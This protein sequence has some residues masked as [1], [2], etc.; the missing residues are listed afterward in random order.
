MNDIGSKCHM[1]RYGYFEPYA[2]SKNTLFQ[3]RE[4]FFDHGSTN[5]FAETTL[6]FSG[7]TDGVT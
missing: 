4:F 3:V 1:N 6:G 2:R 7:L 5:G